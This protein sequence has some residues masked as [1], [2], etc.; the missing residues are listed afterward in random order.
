MKKFLK[1]LWVYLSLYKAGFFFSS[2]TNRDYPKKHIIR[3]NNDLWGFFRLNFE[4]GEKKEYAI[5]DIDFQ[6]NL[7]YHAH[8]GQENSLFRVDFEE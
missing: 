1:S 3:K 4:K 2:N 5:M 7:F 8:K 6:E